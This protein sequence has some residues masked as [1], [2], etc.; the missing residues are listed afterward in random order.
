MILTVV[1][2][3]ESGHPERHKPV[4]GGYKGQV[5]RRVP[6]NLLMPVWLII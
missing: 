3:E 1:L 6:E 2:R 5:L 4:L